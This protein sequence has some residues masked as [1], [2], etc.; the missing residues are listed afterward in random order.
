M[1]LEC[2]G[3]DLTD[4]FATQQRVR[5]DGKPRDILVCDFLPLDEVLLLFENSIAVFNW[6]TGKVRHVPS[7]VRG[8]QHFGAQKRGRRVNVVVCDRQQKSLV[9]CDLTSGETVHICDIRRQ[10]RSESPLVPR[11]RDVR[12]LV[13]CEDGWWSVEKNNACHVLCAPDVST[14]RFVFGENEWHTFFGDQIWYVASL[15]DGRHYIVITKRTTSLIDF[16]GRRIVH[17]AGHQRVHEVIAQLDDTVFLVFLVH[18]GDSLY[19]LNIDKAQGAMWFEFLLWKPAW[20]PIVLSSDFIYAASDDENKGWI[21]P[22]RTGGAVEVPFTWNEEDRIAIRK[23]VV[24]RLG[25]LTSALDIVV[26]CQKET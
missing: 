9:E 19:L 17:L 11:P 12:N 20:K 26:L 21:L 10:E 16:P 4:E 7:S 5:L 13:A 25:S 24:L 3:V 1:I 22:W 18:K 6:C 2:V 14:V 8:A 23:N 15:R